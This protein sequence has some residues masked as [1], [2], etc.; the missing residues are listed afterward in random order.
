MGDIEWAWG[1]WVWLDVTAEW[2]YVL[3]EITIE[4]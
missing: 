4:E 2:V 1:E 3:T